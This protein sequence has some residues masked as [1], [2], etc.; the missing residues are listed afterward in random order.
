MSGSSVDLG[1][2]ADAHERPT[3][4]P[5]CFLCRNLRDGVDRTCDAFPDG[6]PY[7]I[8]AGEH[9]HRTPVPGDGGITFA[10]LTD[11]DLDDLER[12]REEASASGARPSASVAALSTE[13]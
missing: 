13:H 12:H 4:S 9:D 11:A 7:A 1:D 6:I 8:W 2:R 10:R 3:A 5:T